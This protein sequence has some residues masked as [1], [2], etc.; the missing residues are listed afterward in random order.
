MSERQRVSR[1]PAAGGAGRA[2]TTMP[3]RRRASGRDGWRRS[4]ES[5]VPYLRLVR[6]D[7]SASGL[8]TAGQIPTEDIEIQPAARVPA[9][10][11]PAGMSVAAGGTDVDVDVDEGRAQ[12]ARAGHSSIRLT[13]R[14]RAVLW[15]LVAGLAIAALV[16]LAPASRA[17]SPSGP[18][19]TATVHQGDTMWSI[20]T[21]MLPHDSPNVAIE[22]IRVLNHLSD[23]EVYVGE[24]LLIPAA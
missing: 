17:A 13:R 22:R 16:L 23:D 3:P 2:T 4:P 19:R 12:P 18:P 11:R 24:Q 7:E 20:A 21:A 15:L 6:P 9:Q 5:P 1:Y 14:G 8:V 10:R